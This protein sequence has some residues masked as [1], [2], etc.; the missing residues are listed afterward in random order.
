MADVKFT[1]WTMHE[2]QAFNL[3]LGSIDPDLFAADEILNRQNSRAGLMLTDLH[4]H[5]RN[6][7]GISVPIVGEVITEQAEI[8]GWSSESRKKATVSQ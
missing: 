3:T 4:Q 7:V 2:F 8:I 5:V 1:A 6:E